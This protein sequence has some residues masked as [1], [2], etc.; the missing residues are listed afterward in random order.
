MA[1]ITRTA[2]FTTPKNF[3]VKTHRLRLEYRYCLDWDA[4][5]RRTQGE[6][7]RQDIS[8]HHDETN[9]HQPVQTPTEHGIEVRGLIRVAVSIAIDVG[10]PADLKECE[11]QRVGRFYVVWRKPTTKLLAS[12]RS[13]GR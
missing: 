3:V 12:C 11:G 6:K 5:S 2:Q 8:H 13:V 7:T 9:L 10:A 1:S 4:P